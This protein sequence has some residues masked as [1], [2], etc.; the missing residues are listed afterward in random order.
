MIMFVDYVDGRVKR[1]LDAFKFKVSIDSSDSET[2][3][4]VKF[5]NI[6]Q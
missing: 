3:L 4:F 2:M 5:H 1:L 6:N